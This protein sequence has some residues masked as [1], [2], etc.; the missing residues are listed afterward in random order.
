MVAVGAAFCARLRYRDLLSGRLRLRGG[1]CR[2]RT[3]RSARL[4]LVG[5]RRRCDGGAA[6]W[7]LRALFHRQL[8]GDLSS[9]RGAQRLTLLVVLLLPDADQPVS[10]TKTLSARTTEFRQGLAEVLRT[11]PIFVAA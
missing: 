2:D 3:R 9:S 4:V 10:E 5:K 8:F 7:R 11:P 1:P 6:Y